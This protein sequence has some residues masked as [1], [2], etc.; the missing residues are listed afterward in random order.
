[1]TDSVAIFTRAAQMLAEADTI[2]KT[3]ELKDLAL[4]ARD[5]AIRK[6]LGEDAVRHAQSYALRAERKMGE[7]LKATE[8]AKG[9]HIETLKQYPTSNIDK[10]VGAPTLAELG[11]KKRE[12]SRAQ[13]IADLPED[14]FEEIENGN[15]TVHEAIK[16]MKA[17]KRQ[18][19]RKNLAQSGENIQPMDRW[20][21]YHGNIE[22]IELSKQYDFIITDP[23]YPKEYLP[24]WEVLAKRAKEWLKPE[25]LLV[26]MSGQLY[27]NQIFEMFNQ[28][29]TYYWTACYLTLH[30]PTPLRTRNV[31]T[32]WKPVLIYGLNDKYTG[33]IFGDVYRSPQP[34]KK[35]HDWEQSVDGMY[36]LVK[37]IC[38]P[39][40]SILDPFC[41]SGTT[42]VA[43]LKHGCFFD[44]VDI[45]VDSVNIAKR[46]LHDTEKI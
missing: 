45:D 31:N 1:M 30:Q 4:T 18:E 40:Q 19:E 23:P 41:G 42:G 29:L 6:G 10:P 15:I 17:K 8:R 9:G 44:G 21:V 24:L 16:K 34:E 35:N 12:S 26:A 5:W 28:H 25:G 3:K 7:M 22:T 32:T 36:A 38:L 20:N 33:K 46:R 13:L 37:Q 14:V 2:Q 39:G 11:L 27:L 43:A